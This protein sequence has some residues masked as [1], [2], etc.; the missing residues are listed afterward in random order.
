MQT[1]CISIKLNDSKEVDNQTD[2]S[3]IYNYLYD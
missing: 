3:K 1:I 2:N